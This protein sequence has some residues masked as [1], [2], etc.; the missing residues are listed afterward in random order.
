MRSRQLL[1]ALGFAAT[2]TAAEPA[3]PDK[4][5]AG[6]FVDVQ[7]AQVYPDQK[8]FVDGTGARAAA[9]IRCRTASAG[10]TASR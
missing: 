9:N 1:A 8:T 2:C 6:L 5:Y 10:R 3:S 7:S 4:L